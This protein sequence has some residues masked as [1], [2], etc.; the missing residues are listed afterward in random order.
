MSRRAHPRSRGENFTARRRFA[1]FGGSSPLTRGK[2]PTARDPAAWRGLIPAHAGKTGGRK[3][4]ET[5]G[6]WLIPAHA[7]KTRSWGVSFRGW[8]LIPAHAGKTLQNVEV[9]L[10]TTAHPRSRGE[11]K[12]MRQC[13]ACCQG[14]SPLTR[15]KRHV[16]PVVGPWRGL[17]P[18]HAGKTPGLRSRTCPARAHPRSRGENGT[19]SDLAYVTEGSSPLT[20][21]KHLP[22]D[23]PGDGPGLIPAHAGKT[24]RGWMILGCR[25]AHPRSRGENEALSHPKLM[26]LGSSPLTRGKLLRGQDRR[27]RKRLI[28]AHAGKTLPDLRFYR[29]DRS[30]LG[31][32]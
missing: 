14:S 21:G 3:I 20:R 24:P 27:D 7:G 31:K 30:D 9:I 5:G 6:S 11:N 28:P 23:A 32:P 4:I 13:L 12:Q 16:R 15:G 25:R 10:R 22:L 19:R 2:L 26:S 1:S 8:G 17:I 29:A 18:A